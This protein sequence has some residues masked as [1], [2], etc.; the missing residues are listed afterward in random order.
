MGVYHLTSLLLPLFDTMTIVCIDRIS[1]KLHMEE[2]G[3][4][5]FRD[6]QGVNCLE[7]KINNENLFS[8]FKS[9][10]IECF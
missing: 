3:L 2:L 6:G 4:F 9:D 5:L 8:S 1:F 7:N 10:M